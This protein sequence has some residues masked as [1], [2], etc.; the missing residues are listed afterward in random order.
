MAFFVFP[1]GLIDVFGL[2]HGI[3]DA[4]RRTIDE[5]NPRLGMQCLLM[6]AQ[7][8]IINGSSVIRGIESLRGWGVG[9]RVCR[10]P[11]ALLIWLF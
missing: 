1:D 9:C 10:N 8:A 6:I 4:K 3:D 2:C 11:D 7:I 5:E